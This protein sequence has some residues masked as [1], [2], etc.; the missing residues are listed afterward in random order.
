[1]PQHELRFL[2]RYRNPSWSVSSDEHTEHRCAFMIVVR[3]NSEFESK[4]WSI[5]A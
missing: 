3:G 5:N 4:N 1:M 2:P